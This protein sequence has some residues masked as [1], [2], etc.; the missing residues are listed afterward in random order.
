MG[1]TRQGGLGREA[2]VEEP[3]WVEEVWSDGHGEEEE[4]A[5]E[6]AEEEEGGALLGT[7]GTGA[8]EEVEEIISGGS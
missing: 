3:R 2:E 1:Y 8:T 4:E 7:R 6:V 5:E